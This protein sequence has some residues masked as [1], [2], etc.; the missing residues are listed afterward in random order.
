LLTALAR[1]PLLLLLAWLL[2]AALLAGLLPALLLLSGALI[3]LLVLV[4]LD[5]LPAFSRSHASRCP[6]PTS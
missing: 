6:G 4:H 3:G 2:I 5:F 1:T